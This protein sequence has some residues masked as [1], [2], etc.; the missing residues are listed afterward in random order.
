MSADQAAPRPRPSRRKP[1]RRRIPLALA[2]VLCALAL[3]AGL[4]VGY[5]VRG[6]DAPG[7]LVT[8]T[9]PVPVVT[10]TVPAGQ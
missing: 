3:L 10:V 8:E 4:V 9:R 5:A 2:G 7:G 6:S 1:P